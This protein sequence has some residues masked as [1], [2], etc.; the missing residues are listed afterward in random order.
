MKKKTGISYV[1]TYSVIATCSILSVLSSNFIKICS[2]NVNLSFAVRTDQ[3]NILS[4]PVEM[5]GKDG[6]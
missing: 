1:D 2:M 5:C 4:P 3:L 6:R